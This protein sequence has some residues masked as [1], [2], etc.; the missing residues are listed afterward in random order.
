MLL[1]GVG[2]CVVCA[3]HAHWWIYSYTFSTHTYTVKKLGEMV[4]IS[5][6]DSDHH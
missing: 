5:V 1:A 4:V 2:E 3:L 6:A